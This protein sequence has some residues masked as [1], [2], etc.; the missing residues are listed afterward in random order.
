MKD[1]HIMRTIAVL[2]L[3]LALFACSVICFAS[4]EPA[5]SGQSSSNANSDLYL[6]VQLTELKISSLKPGDVIEGRLARDVYSA[7]RKVFPAGSRLRL[8]VDSLE[9]KLRTPNDQ[10]PWVVKAFT[11]R[12]KKYPVFKTAMVS[13]VNGE[14]LLQV[15]V[16]S[17][18]RKREVHAQAKK[19]GS[20]QAGVEPGAVEV[21]KSIVADRKERV[22]TTMVLATSGMEEQKT[23]SES[24]ADTSSAGSFVSTLATLPAGTRCK[25]LLLGNVSASKSI[26]GD[27]IQA[28]LL[29]PVRLDSR[30]ALPAGSTFEGRVVTKTPP[31]WLSRA[32]SLYLTFTGVTLPDGTRF[33]MAASLAGAEL[34]QRSHTRID[35]EGQLRGERP[36]K[37]WMAIN[38]GVTSGLAK[39]VDDTTQL[40]IEAI[41]SSA[42]DVST[43][44]TARIASTCISGIFMLTR[45]G[46]DV[47]LP[48]F[49]EMDISLDRPLSLTKAVESAS[50]SHGN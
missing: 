11:P 18:S 42:T 36:G 16:I 5:R 12:H 49:T 46:R 24:D 25:I 19:K 48:R 29:E 7:N 21:S 10:W 38:I 1:S 6:K 35:A 41:V 34:D 27:P 13:G 44:G 15:S 33:P 17:I 8:T 31:R 20:E 30:V 47:V 26:P 4:E 23:H 39:E 50:A 14:S 9:N 37:A 22:P 40:I 43:A 45:H 28:R 32:G 3:V 2:S